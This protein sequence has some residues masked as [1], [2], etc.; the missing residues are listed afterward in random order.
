L[1]SA[2]KIFMNT[3]ITIA[4]L[5]EAK[6]KGE[7]IAAV[8]CYDYTTAK[9]VSQTGVEM[10][11]VGDSAAQV[12]LGFDTTLPATMDFMLAITAAV[13]RAAPNVCLVADMPFLSYQT[14]INK[15][16]E[17]AGRFFTDCS[18]QMVK[19]EASAPYLD[20]VKSVSDAGMA[21][22]A[23]I[24]IR[25]QSIHKVGR[26]KAQATTAQQA[27]QLISLADQLVEA[28]AG[29]LLLEGTAAE[30]SEIITKR[31]ALPVIGCGSGSACDGQILIAP[32][33]LG[34]TT[35]RPKFAKSY[36]NMADDTIEAFSRYVKDIK[37]KRFPD[38]EHS[39]HMKADEFK[40]LVELLKNMESF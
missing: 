17:N 4:D 14:G 5:V 38:G 39:Y 15:A 1:P 18:V 32:D 20:V 16:V 7:K 23:H 22:M 35:D 36:C 11:L 31:Y 13:R 19:I 6:R 34:L 30:V 24:G 9:M 40:K 25:P 8:S 27:E 33:I 26:L 10:I 12:M 28:G 29:S 3:K 37:G 21:V 2:E